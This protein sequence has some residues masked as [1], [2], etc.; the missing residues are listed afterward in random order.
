[1]KFLCNEIEKRGFTLIEILV[2]VM[3]MAIAAMVA[4][5][6]VSSAGS[7]QIRSAANMIAADLEY[8][9]SIAISKGQ[10]YSMLFNKSTETYTL[11]DQNGSTI[12]HPV[13]IG[14]DY[15][16]NFAADSRLDKVDILDVDFDQTNIVSFDYLGSPYNGT[17]AALNSGAVT[18]RAGN[19]LMTIT[20]E[21][22]TGYITISKSVVE[23]D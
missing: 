15:Q 3:I 10:N 18:L 7:M 8:A 11:R 14:H 5:P 22:V 13:N 23:A 4:L 21:P 6:M 9:K 16:I 20:V 19:V 12:S 17:G 1:M 2:V